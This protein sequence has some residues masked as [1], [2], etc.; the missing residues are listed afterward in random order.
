MAQLIHNKVG[1]HSMGHIPQTIPI[2]I[3]NASLDGVAP[4]AKLFII[5]L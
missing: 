3:V 4:L 2:D 5:G 1:I